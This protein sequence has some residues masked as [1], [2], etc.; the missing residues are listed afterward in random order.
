MAVRGLVIIYTGEGKGKTT[1]ALGLALRAVGR[2]MKVLMI[3]FIK[4]AGSSGEHFS[5]GKL[6]PEFELVPTGKGFVGMAG[7]T[8]PFGEHRK[9]AEMGLELARKR[10]M[11]GEYDIV[12]LDEICC[13]LS[14]GLLR[15][16]DVIELIDKKP[17]KVTLVLTGR[18]ANPRLLEKADLVTEMREVKHP[19]EKGKWAKIGI[20]L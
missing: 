12:I 7:D 18:G 20:D 9:A 8:H 19:F 13:A 4:E 15:I 14:L 5:V 6:E 2:R 3:Q 16:E 1:A 11:S 17:E 10:I